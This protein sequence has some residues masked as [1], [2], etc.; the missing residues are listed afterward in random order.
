MCTYLIGNV[1]TGGLFSA[2]EA[3]V[4]EVKEMG[5]RFRSILLFLAPE[6]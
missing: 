3:Q 2:N 1:Y 5:E 4:K 6:T